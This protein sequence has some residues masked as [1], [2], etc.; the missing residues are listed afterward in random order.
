MGG[1]S[2]WWLH[3]SLERLAS[4]L[5]ARGSRLIIR[6]G[7]PQEVLP[8]LCQETGAQGVVW[9]R[10]YEPGAI[11]T[12]T[13]LKQLLKQTVS[14]VESFPGGL[15]VEPWTLMGK[16]GGPM[17]VFTPFW[18]RCLQALDPAP[19][20]KAPRTL[21]APSRWPDGGSVASLG[22]LPRVAWYQSMAEFWQPGEAGAQAL[23]RGFLKSGFGEY[24]TE[25]DRPD[26]AGTSRLSPALHFGEITPRQI[27][28]AVQSHAESVGQ[29]KGRWRGST[30]LSEVGWREFSAYTLYHFPQSATEPLRPEFQAFPWREHPEHLRAWQRGQTG[31]PLVDAG[32]RE[33]WALGWMHNRVRMVVASFLVKHLQVSWREGAAWF[34]DTLVDAD[35]ACNTM[36]WQWT[37]GCGVDAAP[38]FRIFN[39]ITQGEKF[40][41]S[42]DY[43]RR[44]VP[45]LAGLPNKW[46]NRPW[47]APPEVLRDAGVVLEETYPKPLVDH[48]TARETALDAYASIKGK[49]T[50][51]P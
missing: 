13:A 10:R 28:A 35:L 5:E 25:R 23:L 37:A 21:R 24:Q 20:L 26:R 2:R 39:P 7:Q 33:L 6:D 44:W 8:Q 31:Y 50:A 22:L 42:G 18:R 41:P 43:V 46:L 19:P 15:L 3:H 47:E 36:G 16:S 51:R 11:E 40:D 14:W 34:W 12:D 1:A 49:S 29:P 4:D 17:K 38:Y 48:R 45:E 27:W 9:N 32:M 30:Y